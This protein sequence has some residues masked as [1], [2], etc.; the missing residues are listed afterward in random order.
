MRLRIGDQS[1]KWGLGKFYREALPPSVV[2]N[3][4]AWFVVVALRFKVLLGRCQLS[5]CVR[6]RVLTIAGLSIRDMADTS[7]L[8]DLV[9]P[10]A[11]LNGAPRMNGCLLFNLR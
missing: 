1:K 11:V 8:F 3:G 6:R 2:K 5:P 9:L 10:L 4:I 7:P